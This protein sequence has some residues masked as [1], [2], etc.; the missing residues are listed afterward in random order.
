MDEHGA[1]RGQTTALV[2]GRGQ[3]S[4]L[5]QRRKTRGGH[6]LETPPGRRDARDAA[7]AP[8]AFDRSTMSRAPCPRRCPQLADYLS[9]RRKFDRDC[10]GLHED[11][12][13]D[14]ASR[15]RP[16]QIAASSV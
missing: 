13:A 6:A 9:H 15:D 3:V 16:V 12:A 10:R 4:A 8:N 14:A 5:L 11:I 2:E 7:F 1:S